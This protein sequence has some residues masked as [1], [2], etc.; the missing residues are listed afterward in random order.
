MAEIL[1]VPSYTDF[2]LAPEDGSIV[3]TQDTGHY[4]R[5]SN[6]SV[7]RMPELTDLS[8]RRT[9]VNGSAQ[10]GTPVTGDIVEW[11]QS[12]TTTSGI[13]TF[14]LTTDGTS[15]GP[16]ICTTIFPDSIQTNF[17]DS[18]GVYAPGLA[19][20]TSN[21]SVGIPFT[22]QGFSGVTLI[23]INVLGSVTMGAIPNG[24]TVKV[25]LVGIAA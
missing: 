17:I 9:Y 11:I 6:S 23:G 12:T 2:P 24:V 18:S 16:A 19:V 3:Y 25:M 5:V 4:Y 13:A 10:N 20:I 15:T 22:K 21:K 8:I 1:T 7:Y 14:N